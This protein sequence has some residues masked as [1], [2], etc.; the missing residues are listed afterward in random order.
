MTCCLT[1]YIVSKFAH[2]LKRGWLQWIHL[3]WHWW[4]LFY[5]LIFIVFILIIVIFV[6]YC[7]HF[8][9]VLFVT[10]ISLSFLFHEKVT[11]SLFNCI[12]FQKK[13]IKGFYQRRKKQDT[14]ERRM[15]TMWRTCKKN[16][17]N[18]SNKVV[19][20]K[21]AN[22]YLWGSL[23]RKTTLRGCSYSIHI[24]QNEKLCI[25]RQHIHVHL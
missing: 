14:N 19:D 3:R 1:F 21:K 23:G 18:T 4:I 11:H 7:Y 5:Y 15:T 16:I 12:W 9:A 22:L 2:N 24:Y 10:S 20:F 6:F 17:M 25:E 8:Y 13:I